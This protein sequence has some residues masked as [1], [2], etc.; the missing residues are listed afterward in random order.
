MAVAG[1]GRPPRPESNGVAVIQPAEAAAAEPEVEFSC[2]QPCPTHASHL[3]GRE[4]MGLYAELKA[5][6]VIEAEAAGA[7]IKQTSR[8][9]LTQPG[10]SKVHEVRTVAQ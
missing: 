10:L 2:P 8:R 4:A 5:G 7:G 6:L 3:Q 9:Q 1:G